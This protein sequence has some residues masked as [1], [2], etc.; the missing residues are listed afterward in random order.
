[1]RHITLAT[2]AVIGL[3]GAAWGQTIPE[4][5]GFQ[6]RLT[7][8]SGN[9]VTGSANLT[10][11]LYTVGGTEKWSSG[12]LGVTLNGGLY[13]VQ[14]GDTALSALPFDEAYHL[15]I[16]VESDAEMTPRYPLLAA[17][18]AM[19]AKKANDSERLDGKAA[20][21]YLDLAQ[22]T[23]ALSLANGGTGA[24][25]FSAGSVIFSN[26]TTLSHDNA[27]LFWDETNHRLGIGTNTPSVS[28]HVN[29]SDMFGILCGNSA[30][31][32][33]AIYAIS[34]ADTGQNYGVYGRSESTGGYGVYGSVGATTGL[35]YGVYGWSNSTMGTGVYGHA[36]ATSGT[37]YGL[38][39]MSYSTDG[40]GV[41]GW[42]AAATGTTYGVYGIAASPDGW[43][44]YTPNRL[45][46]G[47]DVGIGTTAPGARLDVAGGSI[48]TDAQLVSMVAP[49]TAPIAVASDTLV[50][51][52][53]SDM[54]DGLHAAAFAPA[55]GGGSYIQNQTSADQDAGLRITGNG[56]FNGGKVGIGTVAPATAI[57]VN[58]DATVS[59][60][61]KYAASRQRYHAVS[62]HEFHP[63]SS[64][65]S[66]SKDDAS[67][68]A[69]PGGFPNFM[70]PVHL[71]D[72][73]VIKQITAMIFD[74][75][76]SNGVSV[77]L[78]YAP[79]FDTTFST[80]ITSVGS[81]G[82]PGFVPLTSNT[83]THVVDN[84]NYFY[85]VLVQLSPTSSLSFRC[86][87]I[88]YLVNSAD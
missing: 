85:F 53:N 16:Q 49:G 75:D 24:T 34:Y 35:T 25:S 70:A 13:C 27:N 22:H 19:R 87:R 39:G 10:F 84:T 32:C 88:S 26:G 14:L 59:G 12:A 54:L 2:L 60:D 68:Q 78:R 29:S 61:F 47:G 30:T 80:I 9:P 77:Q 67:L 48:R 23:G 11:K 7:D 18:Y 38:Y 31:P 64:A 43:G 3:A 62:H 73:A 45:Y 86:A 52:L 50:A 82:T 69:G 33:R 65:Q 40:R 72:K 83:V 71:P 1:M 55:S 79:I 74:G 4:K 42:A 46:A 56:I 28:L 37:T 17:P 5:I 20:S 66:W 76:P 51:N 44:L 81:D 8:A 21:V 6:G 41:H 57:D 63:Q 15:G 58:G 36:N